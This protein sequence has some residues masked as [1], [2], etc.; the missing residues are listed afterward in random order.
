M[1]PSKITITPMT[2]AHLPQARALSSAAGWPHRI[3]DWSLALQLGRGLVALEAGKVAGTVMWWPF[4]ADRA[5]LGMVIVAKR[6]RRQGLGRRLMEGALAALGPQTIL[7]H[8]TQE[9]LPLYKAMGAREIGRVCQHQGVPHGPETISR[10]KARGLLPL[11]ARHLDALAELDARAT[12][13]NRTA[14][15]QALFET[16]HGQALEIDGRLVGYALFR[17]FGR[18][19]LIGPVVA[20]DD[21]GARLLIAPWLARGGPLRI[22]IPHWPGLSSWLEVRGLPKVD[23]VVTMTLGPALP[24]APATPRLFALASQALG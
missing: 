6:C 2:A 9:G 3:A 8:A 14:M 1:S 10:G 16:G 18:G 11:E 5:A 12:G 24:C 19:H 7:L 13:L 22:D 21:H 15:L 17:R 23:E 20:P 4:G